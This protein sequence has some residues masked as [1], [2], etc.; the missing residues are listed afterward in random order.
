M[1]AD[2][3][4]DEAALLEAIVAE[5]DAQ[6]WSADTL[7]RIATLLRDAGYEI[8]DVEECT[9]DGG[10]QGEGMVSVPHAETCPRFERYP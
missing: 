5:M 3:G 2:E 4:I 9:C 10:P 7:E 1:G 6:E 8:R